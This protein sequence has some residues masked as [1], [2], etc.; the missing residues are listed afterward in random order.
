MILYKGS[1]KNFIS[2]TFVNR[3]QLPNTPHPSPYQLG[4]VQQD[5]PR[6]LINKSC[7]VTFAI[8][9]FRDTVDCDVSLLDCFYL[10]L[11]IPY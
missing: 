7:T 3:L 11:K 8:G 6:I 5:D 9:P 4:W 2:Q 10:L 1:Q